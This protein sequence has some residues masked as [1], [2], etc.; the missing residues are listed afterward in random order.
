MKKHLFFASLILIGFTAC[1][2]DKKADPEPEPT[3]APVDPH[4]SKKE[5]VKES[6]ASIA[7]AAYDDSYLGAL[8]LKTAINNFVATPSSAGFQTC[9]QKWLDVREVYGLT[10][11]FRF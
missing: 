4:A 2:K 1:K 8:A 3:P 6:Y 7:F 10:E 9:R 11:T 5:Q